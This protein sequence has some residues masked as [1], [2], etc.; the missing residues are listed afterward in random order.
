MTHT[1]LVL[2]NDRLS[3][4]GV[5]GPVFKEQGMSIDIRRPMEDA[6][7]LPG[8]LDGIDGIVVLGGAMSALDDHLYPGLGHTMALL[9]TARLEKMPV[10]GICLGGQILARA[11]G[12]DAHRDQGAEIGVSRLTPTAHMAEDPLL[13]G[14]EPL[15]AMEMHFDRFDPPPGA[16]ELATSEICP[17]QAF[18]VDRHLWGFQFHPEVS[19]EILAGW[20]A[21]LENAGDS[22]KAAQADRLRRD[23][24]D[25]RLTLSM[26]IGRTIARRWSAIVKDETKVALSGRRYQ[27]GMVDF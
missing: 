10:L 22:A 19:P 1:I 9:N 24:T 13:F 7:S 15:A 17:H 26:E 8:R 18:R 21:H 2:Q 23:L 4:L 12:G 5:L 27:A 20:I 3:P 6:E 14:L 25:D 11:L 16:V